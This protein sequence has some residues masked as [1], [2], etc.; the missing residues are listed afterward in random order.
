MVWQ[1]FRVLQAFSVWF[2][3]CSFYVLPG[4]ECLGLIVFLTAKMV[5][6]TCCIHHHHVHVVFTFT[7]F[8]AEGH[9]DGER[10]GASPL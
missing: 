5:V 4:E 8:V 9:E 7:I 1:E 10:P 2:K 6:C 3:L